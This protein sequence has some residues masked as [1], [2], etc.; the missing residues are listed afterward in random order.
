MAVKFNKSPRHLVDAL[1]GSGYT[2]TE[3][4]SDAGDPQR[5]LRMRL[6]NGTYMNW[7]RDSRGVWAEGPA[8]LREKLE[9]EV[10]RI[11]DRPRATRARAKKQARWFLVLGSIAAVAAWA[12]LKT[13]PSPSVINAPPPIPAALASE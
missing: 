5:S 3:I 1:Q 9:A 2:V 13:E 11:A 8:K 12:A 4:W 7:D 10:S 6:N